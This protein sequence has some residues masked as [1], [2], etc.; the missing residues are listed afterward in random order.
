MSSNVN[1]PSH[2]GGKD[3]P[4]EVIKVAEAWGFDRDAYLF[5]VLK[6]IGRPG[7]GDYLQDLEKAAFYLNRRIEQERDRQDE[8]QCLEDVNPGYEVVW[9]GEKT[10]KLVPKGSAKSGRSENTAYGETGAEEVTYEDDGHEIRFTKPADRQVHTFATHDRPMV[11][12]EKPFR[13]YNPSEGKY[14]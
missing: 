14:E 12:D 10:Y 11:R 7:K 1:H 6:Y 4:Y 2:Y 5:N 13:R 8:E 9:T 3:N